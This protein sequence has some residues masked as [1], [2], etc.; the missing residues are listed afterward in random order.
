M[1]A[2]R[3][4]LFHHGGRGEK[5]IKEKSGEFLSTDFAD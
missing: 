4:S 1:A 5:R 2:A 3:L